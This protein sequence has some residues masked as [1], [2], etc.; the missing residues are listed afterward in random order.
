MADVAVD[1][2]QELLDQLKR[3]RLA[4]VDEARRV[5]V[6]LAIH[7][8]LSEEVSIG[9]AAE[10][11]GS[12]LIEFHDLLRTLDLPTAVYGPEEYAQDIATI[13]AVEGERGGGRGR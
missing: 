6:A 2:P 1:V 3:S 9:R 13:E 11:A 10:L 8:F 7:L 12:P 5:R 4:R